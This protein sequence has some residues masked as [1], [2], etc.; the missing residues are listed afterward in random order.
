M[1]AQKLFFGGPSFEGCMPMNVHM[2]DFI[3]LGNAGRQDE[4]LLGL[5]VQQGGIDVFGLDLLVDFLEG[6]EVDLR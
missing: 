3:L 5:P 1:A 6:V 4:Q 2:S